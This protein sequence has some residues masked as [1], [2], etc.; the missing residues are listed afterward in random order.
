MRRLGR[1]KRWRSLAER[2]NSTPPISITNIFN[3]R[4]AES[5]EKEK[6]QIASHLGLL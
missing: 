1:V 6:D 2:I 4:G 5:A 3:R